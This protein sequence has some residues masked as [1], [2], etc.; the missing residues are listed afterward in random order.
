[1]QSL[2]ELSFDGGH[3]EGAVV[4]VWAAVMIA[5]R[6]TTLSSVG[7]RDAGGERSLASI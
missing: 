7:L 2:S 1:M 5:D 4:H 3:V 6:V